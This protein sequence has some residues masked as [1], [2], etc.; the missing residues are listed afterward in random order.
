M[1]GER[2]AERFL[3]ES[4]AATGGMGIVYRG[5]DEQTGAQV[6]IKLL[7][8]RDAESLA[9]FA[10]EAS[11][12]ADLVHPAIVGYIAHGEHD[13]GL[14]YIVMDWIDG[15]TLS[16]RL[17]RAPLSIG[18]AVAAIAR[19]AGALGHAHA[20]GIVHRD[21][22]PSN[23]LLPDRD[24]ARIAVVDFGIARVGAG[25]GSLTETGAMIGTPSYMAPEQARGDRDVGT[26]ADVFALGCVLYE[27][28]TG[29]R[30]FEGK[31]VLALLAKVALWEPPRVRA[32]DA[33]IAPELDALIASMLGK[34]PEVR[35]RDGADVAARLAALSPDPRQARTRRAR[36]HTPSTQIGTPT[37]LASVVAA[38]D[39]K[40]AG[41]IDFIA[42]AA[43]TIEIP[44]GVR[45]QQIR[46]G[47]I[48]AVVSTE[49]P[50]ERA[51]AAARAIR[52]A[53]PDYVIAITTGMIASEGA[54]PI[55]QVVG[56][57]VERTV[58]ALAKEA[59]ALVFA[60]VSTAKRPAGA[61]R[62]DDKTAE[63]LAPDAVIRIGTTP[64]VAGHE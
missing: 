26:G 42:P 28:I 64:Y 33:G 24:L 35:P 32:L 13:N 6:A 46:D 51:L 25:V 30:A 47:S 19:V 11:V 58:A 22:K 34:T 9:R 55:T 36:A 57:L 4:R 49:R 1:L 20:R 15:E 43:E 14:P 40:A 41:E 48:I 12:L 31:H 59:M 29:Q 37:A 39:P 63:L 56:A 8:R 16:A 21:V 10:R 3:V 18:E 17:E 23:M 60:G 54:D 5:R 50:A 52:R 2:L 62:L 45:L 61:I 7:Q 27:C 53:R 44:D 38:A